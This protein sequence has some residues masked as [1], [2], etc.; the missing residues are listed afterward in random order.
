[1]FYHRR[2]VQDAIEVIANDHTFQP[3]LDY[4][5]SLEWD[6]IERLNDWLNLYMGAETTDLNR[7]LGAR[8]L[9]SAVARAYDPGCQVDH[10][11]ILESAQG[12]GKSTA[13]RILG[14]DFFSDDIGELGTKDASLAA[15]KAWIIE[16][17]EL[18]AMTRA[19]VSKIKAFVSRRIDHFRP[20]YGRNFVDVP[21]S[22]VFCGTVN[23]GTKYLK[24]ETGGRRFWPV[25]CGN[26]LKLTDLARDR[27]QLW[28]E[29]VHRYKKG[30]KWWLTEDDLVEAVSEEQEE[31]YLAD[32]WEPLIQTWL[33]DRTEVSTAEVLN[34]CI[35]KQ[36]GQW[37][38]GD[39]MRVGAI[40]HRLSW[41]TSRPGGNGPRRRV[42]RPKEP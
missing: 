40:L 8:W 24:D 1:M 39:E 35:Q 15:G 18:D 38:R 26:T 30:E 12:R 34:A 42:Y 17:A 29:A 25:A 4:L 3:V 16:L 28:A 31:R 7:A 20:P 27:D 41:K 6:G 13:F 2:L 22:S 36:A 11:L 10:I 9:I 19:E 23:P 37:T 21:R 14:G 32:P 5:E 33:L